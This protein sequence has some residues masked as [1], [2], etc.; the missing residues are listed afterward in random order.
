[1]KQIARLLQP[2]TQEAKLNL[3]LEPMPDSPLKLGA[4]TFKPKNDITT[5]ELAKLVE[6]FT[7]AFHPGLTKLY[8]FESFVKS[9]KLERHFVKENV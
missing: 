6:L 2:L 9:N 8:N 3:D 5:Y 7:F 4:H 1:M